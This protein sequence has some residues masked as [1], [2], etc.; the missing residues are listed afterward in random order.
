M[1][2]R[3]CGYTLYYKDAVGQWIE[4]P[5]CRAKYLVDFTS[6]G[7][8]GRG[9]ETLM[10][11]KEHLVFF[12]QKQCDYQTFRMKCFDLLMK[13][14]PADIF[15]KM[16]V[17]EEKNCML[18]YVANIGGETETSYMAVYVGTSNHHMIKEKYMTMRFKNSDTQF[19]AFCRTNTFNDED[20]EVVPV[21]PDLMAKLPEWAALADEVHY[22]PYY[23][24]TG[25]Y[26]GKT[27]SFS[28]LGN[29]EIQ[30]GNIPEDKQLHRMPRLIK[31]DWQ[32][33]AKIKKFAI[34]MLV[35]LAVALANIYWTDI[36]NLWADIQVAAH[37]KWHKM[38]QK[39]SFFA[40]I[41]TFFAG[42][43][44]LTLAPL[45]IHIIYKVSVTI[46]YFVMWLILALGI[47][48]L[49]K[50]SI[51]KRLKEVKG[52]QIKKQ[53]DAYSNFGVNLKELYD[54]ENYLK[55]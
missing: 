42:C 2:C 23:C 1:E 28:S 27:I 38:L 33:K 39:W 53:Q 13:M 29:E 30:T 7:D 5:R 51:K 45:V 49:N 19:G 34:I 55:S 36:C 50:Q 22:Y 52:I 31:I 14:A 15:E 44:S 26:N 25:E 54:M 46:I 41:I 24:L 11:H 32:F 40:Y 20:A 17:K 10:G 12:F 43:V 35:I 37:D 6:H 4:C 48:Q 8:G 47:K 21:D 18:P 9:D 3:S 16:S